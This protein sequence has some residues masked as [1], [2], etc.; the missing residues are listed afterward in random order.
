[1]NEAKEIIQRLIQIKAIKLNFENPFTWSS[2]IKSPI[3]CDN[4]LIWSYPGIRSY[5]I[6]ALIKN[7]E[8]SQNI[9]AIAGVATAGIP[10]AAFLASQ[11]SLPF[12]YV[13]SNSKDHGLENKIEG[14]ILGDEN[15]L[16]I[17]DLISTGGSSIAA[18]QALI[19]RGV[20]I[21]GVHS[22]FSYGL[23]KAQSNFD[24]AG[25]A[26]Q[27]LARLNHLIEY[28]IEN[29]IMS[30]KEAEKLEEWRNTIDK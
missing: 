11:L 21:E 20:K 2:G 3:Y 29:E 19:E 18:A 27:S 9:N 6:N 1:M 12:V 13:R 23:R 17:E 14:R 4:R 10:P 5:I 25:I 24:K 7:N 28:G 16:V 22:I 8:R 15:V 30:K 26:H